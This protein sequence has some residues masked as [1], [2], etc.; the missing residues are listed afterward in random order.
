MDLFY[1]TSWNCLEDGVKY[2]QMLEKDHMYDF[3]QGLKQDLNEVWAGLLGAKPL[4]F[5]KHSLSLEMKKATNG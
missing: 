3:L 5:D 1:E 2:N 4:L